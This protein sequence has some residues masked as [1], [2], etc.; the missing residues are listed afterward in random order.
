WPRDWSSDVCSS[1]LSQ[2]EKTLGTI[3]LSARIAVFDFK[4]IG[5][6]LPQRTSD[7]LRNWL[8]GALEGGRAEDVT[9]TI[10]GDL[11]DFPFRKEHQIGRA[12]CRERRKGW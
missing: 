1:D 2:Q 7:Q 8:T 12:S 9:V 5:H 3:D 11:A 4:K 6:Y 10:K